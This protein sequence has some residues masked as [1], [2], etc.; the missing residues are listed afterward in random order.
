[1][2][3]VLLLHAMLLNVVID[4]NSSNNPFDIV[5]DVLLNLKIFYM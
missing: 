5:I 1:M 4:F 2:K 3:R